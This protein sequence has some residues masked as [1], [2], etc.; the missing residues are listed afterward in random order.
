MRGLGGV[1][2]RLNEAMSRGGIPALLA[3]KEKRDNMERRWRKSLELSS[4]W[5]LPQPS[6]LQPP[7]RLGVPHPSPDLRWDASH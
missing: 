7:P 5:T 6:P 2:E 1:G 3:G 4:C